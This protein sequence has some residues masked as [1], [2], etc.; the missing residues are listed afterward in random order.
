MAQ[1][2]D[3]LMIEISSFQTNV[4]NKLQRLKEDLVVEFDDKFDEAAERFAMIYRQ[5]DRENLKQKQAEAE[6]KLE[7]GEDY[8]LE[9]GLTISKPEE[10][11][12][13]TCETF[14]FQMEQLGIDEIEPYAEVTEVVQPLEV[15]EVQ[16]SV[17]FASK[18]SI[19]DLRRKKKLKLP[20]KYEPIVEDLRNDRCETIDLG[21]A[22]LGDAVVISLCDYVRCSQRLRCLKLIR[23]KLTNDAL[24]PILEACV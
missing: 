20:E 8:L 18:E 5:S 11:S 3:Y 9:E 10:L 14:H 13:D 2:G 23:N 16:E 19:G 7:T 21:G 17:S 6:K 1:R 24:L 12:P 15:R 22:E 4:D